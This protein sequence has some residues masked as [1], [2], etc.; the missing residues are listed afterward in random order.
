MPAPWLFNSG[1][2]T[3]SGTQTCTVR[4][5]HTDSE[6]EVTARWEAVA[7]WTAAA[8]GPWLRLEDGANSMDSRVNQL[9]SAKEA[10]CVQG[11]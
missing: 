1:V 5:H 8:S 2:H 9:P 4:T 11:S 10:Q 6:T 7:V 3:T